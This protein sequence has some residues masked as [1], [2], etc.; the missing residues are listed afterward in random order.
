MGS[1][2]SLLLLSNCGGKHAQKEADFYYKLGASYMREGELQKAFVELQKAKELDPGNKE[3]LNL[4]G[5]LYFQFEDYESSIRHFK[6][7]I[8]ID[9]KFSDARN[10]LGTVYASRKK[11][12]EAISEFKKALENPLYQTPEVALTNLGFV[13][14]RLK[15]YDEAIDAFNKALRRNPNFMRAYLGMSLCYNRKAMYGEA[16]YYMDEALKRDPVYRG[17]RL[18]AIKDMEDKLLHAKNE[19]AEDLRDYLE[20]LRY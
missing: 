1:L 11:W 15:R 10:N 5:L 20:I 19:E 9:K 14:Y 3:V 13:Y 18:K 17:D 8:S 16:A 2:T 6:K 4:L 12:N 7:A